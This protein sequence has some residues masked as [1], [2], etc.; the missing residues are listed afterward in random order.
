[1]GNDLAPSTGQLPDWFPDFLRYLS[2]MRLNSD[3]DLAVSLEGTNLGDKYYFVSRADQYVGAGHTDG[4]P[5][6]PREWAVTLK[7]TF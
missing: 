7:K 5:G 1:V 3:G 6:R 4:Q 2:Q